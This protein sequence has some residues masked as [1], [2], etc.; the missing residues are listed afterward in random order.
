MKIC[1]YRYTPGGNM[2]FYYLPFLYSHQTS[3]LF[4]KPPK[5]GDKIYSA[6]VLYAAAQISHQEQL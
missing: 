2:A 5:Q 4:N 3:S 1:Y 6:W